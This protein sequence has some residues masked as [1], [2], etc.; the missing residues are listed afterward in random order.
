MWA[1]A[2]IRHLRPATTLALDGVDAPSPS[3]ALTLPIPSS[4]SSSSSSADSPGAPQTP[5]SPHLVSTLVLSP[6][7]QSSTPSTAN[8]APGPAS[9]TNPQGKRKPS[10]RANTAKRHTTHN[11]VERR[12]RETLNG[13][14]LVRNYSFYLALFVDFF[15]T[16]LVSPSRTSLPFFLT[17]PRFAALPSQQL[18]T[19]PLP[20]F[21]PLAVTVPWL[22]LSFVS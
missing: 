1:S 21:M 5:I 19:P 14:F 4:P 11:A 9:S 22:L 10:R 7:D 3:M 17:F 20:I 13:R 8:S 2:C 6:S 16:T 18:S 15:L 12:R